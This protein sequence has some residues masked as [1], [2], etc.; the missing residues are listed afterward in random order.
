MEVFF[1]D[2]VSAT[3]PLLVNVNAVSLLRPNGYLDILL[4][5][6]PVH[7]LYVLSALVPLCTHEKCLY[8]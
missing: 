4:F 5:I 1:S 6:L 7:S 3:F 8:K 2:C